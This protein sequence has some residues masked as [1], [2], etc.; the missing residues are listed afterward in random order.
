MFDILLTMYQFI[1]GLGYH[2]FSIAHA[3]ADSVTFI[4]YCL[5]SYRLLTGAIDFPEPFLSL[6]SI[7]I[8]LGCL[9]FLWKG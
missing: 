8:G 5:N 3:F 6:M 1:E 4:R 7:T 9:K 2:L